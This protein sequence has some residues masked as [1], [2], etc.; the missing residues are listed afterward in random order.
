MTALAR[1]ISETPMAPYADVLRSMKPQHMRIVVTFL[2]EAMREAE[3]KPRKEE[4]SVVER[5]R[6][7]YGLKESDS[8]KW[9][10]ELSDTRK[11]WDKQQAWNDLSEKQRERAMQLNLTAED[12]D[13]RTVAIIEKHF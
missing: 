8:T 12:M 5:V 7:K 2:Q 13:E 11:D 9:L 3:A 4:K 10:K 6:E 1:R